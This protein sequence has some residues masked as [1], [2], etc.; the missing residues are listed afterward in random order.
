MDKDVE[1]RMNRIDVNLEMMYRYIREIA[2]R[3][4]PKEMI[5]EFDKEYS[6]INGKNT[7]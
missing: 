3:R 4:V 5:E 6:E 2:K 7:P 1:K